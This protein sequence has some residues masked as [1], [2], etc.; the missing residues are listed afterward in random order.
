MNLLALFKALD[1]VVTFRDVAR[2]VTGASPPADTGLA[3]QPPPGLAGQIETRLTNVVVAAL[4]EAFDRDHARLE[5]ERAQLDEQRRRTEE[6]MRLERRRQAAE[7][8][9]ARLRL[10]AGAAMVGW[11]ASL[12]L[13]GMRLSAASTASRVTLAAGWL[14]LLGALASAF[15]AQGRVGAAASEE[16]HAPETG[17]VAAAALWLLIAGLAVT[18][19]SLLL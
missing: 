13:L 1:A 6:A 9:L 3:Q 2:R 19:T 10:L 7:R 4:K 12:L 17:R 16:A 18:A 15:L 8:E 14:L 11:L 5:L